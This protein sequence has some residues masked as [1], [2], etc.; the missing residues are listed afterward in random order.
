MRPILGVTSVV[1]GLF[2]LTGTALLIHSVLSG[3]D[4]VPVE[5]VDSGM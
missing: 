2:Y 5:T 4:S 3:Y 1:A